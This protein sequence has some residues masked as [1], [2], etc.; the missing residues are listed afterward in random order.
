MAYTGF[1][2]PS[3]KIV[4]RGTPL[5]QELNI[6]VVTSM[7]PGRLAKKGTNDDDI[8]VNTL[9]NLSVGG[10]VGYEQA[11]PAFKPST[12]DDIYLVTAKAPLLSGGGFTIVGGLASGESVSKFAPLAG[13]AAGELIAWTASTNGPVVAYAEESV[14]ASEAAS[15]ILVL[16]VI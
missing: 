12:V 6:E 3:N 10:W 2:K 15:D 16:S 11:N 13:A 1:T 5:V 9:A 4:G 14:D 7:Y 8:V